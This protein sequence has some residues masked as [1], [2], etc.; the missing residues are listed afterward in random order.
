MFDGGQL[1]R[2]DSFTELLGFFSQSLDGL[3]K[4]QQRMLMIC[5]DGLVS[6]G[7][8]FKLVLIFLKLLSR[9]PGP[10]LPFLFF[11]FELDYCLT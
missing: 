1:I 5:N 6:H 7:S 8:L 4:I 10:D 9:M 11:A 3:P 2:I